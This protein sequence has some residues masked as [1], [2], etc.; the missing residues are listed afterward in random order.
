[1][2]TQ[3]IP[4]DREVR[5]RRRFTL[6]TLGFTLVLLSWGAVVTSI[7]AGLAVPD[8]P[9]SFD[10][11]DPLN[12]MPRWYAIPPVLAEHGHRLLGMLVGFCTVILAAW[13]WRSDTRKWMRYL[14]VAALALVILQGTLGGM[15]VVW[16]SL[17]L[18][19]VHACVA[20]LFFSLLASMW[21]FTTPTW[22]AREALP[23]GEAGAFLR[24]YVW[25]AAVL[26]YMQVVLGAL[27]RH[28]GQGVDVGIAMTHMTMAFVVL[29]ALVVVIRQTRRATPAGSMP[30]RLA[31][32]LGLLLLLQIGLG[33][34]AYIVLL[35]EFGIA[36]SGL[37]VFL[38]T[39]HMVVGASLMATTV[40]VSLLGMRTPQPEH[41]PHA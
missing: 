11:Y 7:D 20:Q 14:G 35:K 32:I 25:L 4:D 41:Q 3:V 6:L 23:T 26:L 36:R 13:T 27:L 29:T 19:T 30:Y 37:Q 9:T 38:N 24:R 5:L 15:R 8:W 2:P 18:A 22:T 12:P 40:L 10:S 31:G 17:D 16:Q 39:S 21:L 1:M 28:A 33:F 34:S